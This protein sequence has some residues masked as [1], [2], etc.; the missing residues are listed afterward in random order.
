MLKFAV[1]LFLALFTASNIAAPATAQRLP[2]VS[3]TPKPV[4]TRPLSQIAPVGIKVPRTVTVVNNIPE[5]YWGDTIVTVDTLPTRCKN[6]TLTCHC[7]IGTCTFQLP[8]DA[9][10]LHF[11]FNQEGQKRDYELA[12][13]EGLDCTSSC[14]VPP[15]ETAMKVTFNWKKKQDALV[16]V[17]FAGDPAPGSGHMLW[18]A[19]DDQKIGCLQSQKP[20]GCQVGVQQGKQVTVS[21]EPSNFEFKGWSGACSGTGPCTFVVDGNKAVT[22]NFWSGMYPVNVNFAGSSASVSIEGQPAFSCSI[23]AAGTKGCTRYFEPGAELTLFWKQ[24]PWATPIDAT[25]QGAC[26]PAGK[27]VSCTLKVDGPKNV[28]LAVQ[29]K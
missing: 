2:R 8:N 11:G 22:G 10:T 1:A 27:A 14:Q 7:K 6:G 23:G 4:I 17:D 3:V 20:Q 28:L 16:S 25:W 18:I 5:G 13:V 12:S 9:T 24:G 19:Y 15:P 21:F 26:A 29:P